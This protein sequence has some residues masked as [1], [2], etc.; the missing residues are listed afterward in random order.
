MCYTLFLLH[1]GTHTNTHTNRRVLVDEA[2]ASCK[3]YWNCEGDQSWLSWYKSSAIF[4]WGSLRGGVV[5]VREGRGIH[6]VVPVA[7]LFECVDTIA[8][9]AIVREIYVLRTV[10]IENNK[11]EEGGSENHFRGY[12][13]YWLTDGLTTTVELVEMLCYG[14]GKIGNNYPMWHTDSIRVH[15]QFGFD[16]WAASGCEQNNYSD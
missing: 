13:C 16:L 8:C 3:A 10:V 2:L 4:W 7:N 14:R 12:G 5:D 6:L 15:A 11:E 1:S 9:L